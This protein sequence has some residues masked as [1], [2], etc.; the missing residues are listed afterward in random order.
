MFR[1]SLNKLN[2]KKKT[3]RLKN[4]GNQGDSKYLIGHAFE[5]AREMKIKKLVIQTEKGKE[6]RLVQKLRDKEEIVWLS[7][8]PDTPSLN[9]K[10]N[11]KIVCIPEVSVKK[12]NVINL[13]IFL[14][15]IQGYIN[16][17]ER[18]FCL[19]RVSG[20]Q[21]L[22]RLDVIKPAYYFPWFTRVHRETIKKIFSPGAFIKIVDIALRFAVEGREGKPIG[23]IF[24][25][26][27]PKELKP[28]VRQLILNPCKGH[29]EAKRS[30]YSPDFIEVLREYSSLDG[31]FII[32]R[33]GIVQSAG[34]YLSA[35]VKKKSKMPAGLGA[36]HA[37]AAAITKVSNSLSVVVSESSGDVTVFHRGNSILKLEK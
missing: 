34:A 33:K 29:P 10:L 2:M 14:T 3:Y 11:D 8:S 16:P 32:N 12:L 24:V 36:R 15:L 31:A 25:L 1:R 35:P 20:H 18:I 19:S 30:L 6:V 4:K 27:T 28:Y 17:R 21:N 22:N 9:K 26:G 7:S 13:G 37:A 5:I 23:T